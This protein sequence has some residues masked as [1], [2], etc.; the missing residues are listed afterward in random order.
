MS[1]VEQGPPYYV[2]AQEVLADLGL[3]DRCRLSD[4]TAQQAAY[5]W[6]LLFEL[7]GQPCAVR[8]DEDGTDPA[9]QELI[10]QRLRGELLNHINDYGL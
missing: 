6:C 8:G 2:A 9:E 4:V 1:S 5:R 10:K 7:G 3:R